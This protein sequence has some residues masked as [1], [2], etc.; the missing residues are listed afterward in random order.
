MHKAWEAVNLCGVPVQKNNAIYTNSSICVYTNF[1]TAKH[2][3]RFLRR[4]NKTYMSVEVWHKH[5]YHYIMFAKI[6]K[7]LETVLNFCNFNIIYCQFKPIATK[8]LTLP[9]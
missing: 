4:L 7:L 1:K 3:R 9:C 8:C 6:Q 5:L 2:L